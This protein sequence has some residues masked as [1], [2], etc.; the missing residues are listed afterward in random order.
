MS[1]DEDMVEEKEG[2][3]ANAKDVKCSDDE[4][5]EEGSEESSDSENE[6]DEEEVQIKLELCD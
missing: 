2:K 1:D 5:G 4:K 3:K 6:E